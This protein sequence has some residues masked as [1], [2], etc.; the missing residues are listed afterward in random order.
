MLYSYSGVYI[1]LEICY[2]D[3][4]TLSLSLVTMTHHYDSSPSVRM[5]IVLIFIS[6]ARIVT[7]THHYDSSL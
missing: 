1:I 7:M 6:M 4:S 2:N 5:N 3:R